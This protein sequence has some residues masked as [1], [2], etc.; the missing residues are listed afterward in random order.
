MPTSPSTSVTTPSGFALPHVP[1]QVQETLEQ[2]LDHM[3]FSVDDLANEVGVSDPTIASRTNW[4]K[5]AYHAHT[6]DNWQAIEDAIDALIPSTSVVAGSGVTVTETAKNVYEVAASGGG[7]SDARFPLLGVTRASAIVWTGSLSY[8]FTVSEVRSTSFLYLVIGFEDA[9]STVTSVTSA[10]I[11]WAQPSDSTGNDGVSSVSLWYGSPPATTG[12]YTITVTVSSTT[13]RVHYAF[14]DISVVGSANFV[15]NGLVSTLPSGTTYS[16]PV[17]AYTGLAQAFFSVAMAATMGDSALNYALQS[18]TVGWQYIQ[19]ATLHHVLTLFIGILRP[20]ES[21]ELT[22]TTAV[23]GG[24][25]VAISNH[26]DM[27]G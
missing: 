1:A 26:L 15:S 7:A 18:E 6:I 10:G 20:G 13:A 22:F 17:K 23:A 25:M 12:P 21:F 16:V 8:T 14:A 24:Q 9:V 3:Q 2:G 27:S 4:D 19:D 5:A 11:T